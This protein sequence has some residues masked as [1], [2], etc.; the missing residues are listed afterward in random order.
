MPII[1]T[2][3]LTHKPNIPPTALMPQMNLVCRKGGA[4][5]VV[6]KRY[7]H[8]HKI[9][10]MEECGWLQVVHNLSLRG[11]VRVLGVNHPLLIRWMAKLPALK[12]V[13]GK[14]RQSANKGHVDQLDTFKF[15][16]LAWVFAR[17]KQGIVVTKA[18]VIFKAFA[19][20]HNFGAK[21]F[22]ARFQV[23]SCI[24]GLHGYVYRM[25]MN[26]ATRPPHE[27]YTQALDF[28]ASTRLLLVGPHQDKRYI[29]NMD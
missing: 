22:E 9:Q 15:E 2:T 10:L 1:P 6:H 7:A 11:A 29:W 8:L 27:V 4:T 14:P 17:R 3:Y 16:L 5:D 13:R 23:V 28:L 18:Q 19:L 24:L 26:K 12:A 25:K 20:L 21:T